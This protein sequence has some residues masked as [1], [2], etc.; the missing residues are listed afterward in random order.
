MK[1]ILVASILILAL[2]SSFVAGVL[3]SPASAGGN[4]TTYCENCTCAKI[5]C[6]DGV[7]RQV[8]RCQVCPLIG[9]DV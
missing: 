2:A 7:C 4:C 1:K 5:K 3:T 8:G 9:C 6:C